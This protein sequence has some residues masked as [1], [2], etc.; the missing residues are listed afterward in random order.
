MTRPTVLLSHSGSNTQAYQIAASLEALGYPLRYESGFFYKPESILGR[1]VRALPAALKAPLE[2]ELMRRHDSR[3]DPH[4]IHL[5]AAPELIYVA[6]KRLGLSEPREARLILWRDAVFDR[7][8]ARVV[9]RER[10]RIVI[11]H[12]GQAL[13]TI[14]A[15]KRAGAIAVLN[16]TTGFVD[17][18]LAIYRE[19]AA[20]HPEFED[21]LSS[22]L[23]PDVGADMR[24]EALEANRVLAPSDYVRDSLLE[25][26]VDGARIAMLPYGVDPARFTPGPPRP[27]GAPFRI[28]FVGQIGQKKGIKYLLE[29]VRRLALPKSELVLAGRVIG[30]GR[31][32]APYRDLF[33]HV[34]HVPYGE[35]HRLYQEADIFVF[36][37]LHEGSAFANLEAMASGL[38]V[39]TTPNAGSLVRDGE[40]GYV[41]P[42]RDVDAL[43]AR[44]EALHRDRALRARMGA[45][46]RACAIAHGWNRHCTELDAWLR[47]F[48]AEAA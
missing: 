18:A 48:D 7:H 34:A 33:R 32:L 41:V 37:S 45:S 1:L 6:L 15:A 16:Q 28:L 40:D 46:A 36:P 4:A 9:R 27:A 11:A 13:A 19:E 39:I 5:N 42:I 21:S 29:A 14:R 43:M 47:R 2:R 30:S 10:P 12:D 38:P 31:A 23:P 8:V 35:V 24:R 22:H 25:I 20:R 26:G 17:K 3:L 44:I